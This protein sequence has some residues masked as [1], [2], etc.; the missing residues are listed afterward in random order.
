MFRWLAE[1]VEDARIAAS[2]P[3]YDK[4]RREEHLTAAKR[5]FSTARLEREIATL[6]CEPAREAALRFGPAA[7]ALRAELAGDRERMREL[8]R[9]LALL[10]RDYKAELNG[11]YAKVRET[12]EA[13]GDLYEERDEAR[14][15]LADAQSSID[16]WYRMSNCYLGNRGRKVPRSRVFGRS[17]N[18]LDYEKAQKAKAIARLNDCRAEIED[19]R[20]LRAQHGAEIERVKAARSEMFT[21]KADGAR[22]GAIRA[23]ISDLTLVLSEREA[24][25]QRVEDDRSRFLLQ[26][27]VS[28]G[29]PEREQEVERLRAARRDSLKAFE[30]AAAVAAR[31]AQHRRDWLQQAHDARRGGQAA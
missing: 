28:L 31:K 19:L 9:R 15:V 25:L 26:A 27:R 3:G 29:I 24:S 21:L 14:K 6:A 2:F 17:Q 12:R 4:A 16:H 8:R 20:A 10:E 11:L 22:L 13:L 23:E 7:A 5:R 1:R 30:S 18:D